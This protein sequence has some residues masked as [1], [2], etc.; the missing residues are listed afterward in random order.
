MSVNFAFF[1]LGA[2]VASFVGVVAGRLNTG[3]S[4]LQGRS[5]CDS[6]GHTLGALDLVP[7]VSWL[8]ALGRCRYCGARVSGLSTA[9]EV[10]LGSLYALSYI[11]VGLTLELA[12]LL[13]LLALI[14]G[15]VLY[16]LQH[17]IIPPLLLW[18]AVVLSVLFAWLSFPQQDA[19]L[20]T[21]GA[22]LLVAAFLA[23]LHFLSFGR[24]MGLADAPF[25]FLLAMMVGGN[26]FSGLLFSFWAGAV[27]GVIILA[28]TPVGHR[29]GIEVPFAPFLAFGFLLAYFTTWNAFSLLTDLLLPLWSV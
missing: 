10:V 29:M 8:V 18:P 28:R 7:I 24:A 14:L 4:F 6:C 2:I 22:A 9:G 27:V 21:L 1:A 13:V 23:A 3:N 25:A 5:V 20:S 12:V 19:F 26:A 17:T 11:K 16:D 15:M